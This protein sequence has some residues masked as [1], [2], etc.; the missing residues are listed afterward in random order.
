MFAIFDTKTN[1]VVFTDDS[2]SKVLEVFNKTMPD[3]KGDVYDGYKIVKI[4]TCVKDTDEE[5]YDEIVDLDITFYA[6]FLPRLVCFRKHK[7]ENVDENTLNWYKE[8]DEIIAKLE[9]LVNNELHYKEV[10]SVCE[11]V[12]EWVGKNLGKLWL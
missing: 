2:K 11:M 12:N 7:S 5:L 1:K 3:N 8:I 4:E 9:G 6:W 10:D